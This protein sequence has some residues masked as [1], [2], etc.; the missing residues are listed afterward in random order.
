MRPR[1]TLLRNLQ[2]AET[3]TGISISLDAPRPLAVRGLGVLLSSWTREFVA[4]LR[5]LRGR[6]RPDGE[7]CWERV[8]L[9]RRCCGCACQCLQRP[10]R[11]DLA[12]ERFCQLLDFCATGEAE[13]FS[14]F[15]FREDA[16]EVHLQVKLRKLNSTRTCLVERSAKKSSRCDLI[17]RRS[18]PSYVS[19]GPLQGRH[20]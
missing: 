2:R 3:S 14:I 12:S 11:I 5:S 6:A 20:G 1:S 18:Y 8:M 7:S 19:L 4:P 10:L 13:S 16:S 15:A 17:L 9:D